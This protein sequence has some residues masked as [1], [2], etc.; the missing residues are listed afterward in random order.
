MA[1][2]YNRVEVTA[3]A[4]DFVYAWGSSQDFNPSA[5]LEKIAASVLA[6]NAA[7]DERNPG[8][9]HPRRIVGSPEYPPVQGTDGP[10]Y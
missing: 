5:R 2:Q 1:K 9:L 6:I 8:G 4:N 10:G 3:D 7:D